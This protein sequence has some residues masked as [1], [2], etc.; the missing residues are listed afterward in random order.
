MKV[1]AR[2]TVKIDNIPTRVPNPGTIPPS[3]RSSLNHFLYLGLQGSNYFRLIR[4]RLYRLCIMA[5]T[6]P[7]RIYRAACATYCRWH[8]PWNDGSKKADKHPTLTSHSLTWYLLYMQVSI[9]L[10][11]QPINDGNVLERQIDGFRFNQTRWSRRAPLF[12]SHLW[13]IRMGFK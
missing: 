3:G 5:P 11:L 6:K 2:F 12:L 8:D 1:R 9:W 13:L 10:F 7:W 4:C